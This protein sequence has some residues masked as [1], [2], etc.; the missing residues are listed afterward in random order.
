MQINYILIT[1]NMYIFNGMQWNSIR[2]VVETTLI[3]SRRKY[4]CI[5]ADDLNAFPRNDSDELFI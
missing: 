4:G 3:C 2:S 1:A 5:D